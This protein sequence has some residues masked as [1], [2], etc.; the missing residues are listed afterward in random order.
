[1]CKSGATFDLPVTVAAAAT[2]FFPCCHN[3]RTSVDKEMMEGP[4]DTDRPYVE[5]STKYLLSLFLFNVL[6]YVKVKTF[7]YSHE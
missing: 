6:I 7:L 5:P 1:M 4:K 2:H 3:N